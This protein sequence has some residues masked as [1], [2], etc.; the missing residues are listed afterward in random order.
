MNAQSAV[1]D[2]LTPKRR[3]ETPEY[4]GA[5]RRFIRAAGRRV[6]EGD[7]ADLADLLSL[8]DEIERAIEAGVRGLKADQGHSW[9]Y[10]AG[11]LGTTKQRAQFRYAAVCRDE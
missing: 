6:A 3:V 1:N 8:R 11:G 9:S 7:D 5:A 2:S 10:I 4:I